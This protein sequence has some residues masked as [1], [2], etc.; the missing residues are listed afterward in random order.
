MIVTT[1]FAPSP[2]GDLHLGHILAAK[3][4]RELARKSGG[5]FLLRH[6]DIDDTRVKE[7]C[8]TRIE[9]DLQWLGLTWD[10]EPIRQSNRLEAYAAALHRI[11]ELGLAYPCFCTR[12]DIQAEIG[13]ILAAPHGSEALLYPGLCRDLDG[14]E[15][16]ARIAAGEPH[17]WR[18]NSA[19]AAAL[20]G[21]ISFHDLRHGTTTAVSTMVNGDVVLA[22]KDIGTSYHLAVVVDDAFQKV[23]HVT[24]G[25][26]LLGATHV[27]RQLQAILGFPEPTYLHHALVRDENGIRLAKRDAAK[28]IRSLRQG[29]LPPAAILDMAAASE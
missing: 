17:T 12:K 1:R 10:G 18:L 21:E 2:T 20:H 3:V 28:S 5:T 6:E 27:Q 23:S 24:R 9:Q 7:E 15:T 26:D 19:K 11:R 14:L 4:A 8:Y 22:R 16:K 29:G 25:E 13:K